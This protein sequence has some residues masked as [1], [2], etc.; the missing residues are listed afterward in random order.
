[1]LFHFSIFKMLDYHSTDNLECEFN[2]LVYSNCSLVVIEFLLNMV[3]HKAMTAEHCIENRMFSILL[4]GSVVHYF[5]YFLSWL[6]VIS[7]AYSILRPALFFNEKHYFLFIYFYL[8][9]LFNWKV[10]FLDT[11]WGQGWRQGTCFLTLCSK[12]GCISPQVSH[13]E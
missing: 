3:Q 12:N 8:F 13:G 7:V 1:M 4:L 2:Y 11:L 6:Y 5:L 9:I 10:L